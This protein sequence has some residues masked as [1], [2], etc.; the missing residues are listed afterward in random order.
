MWV[1]LKRKRPLCLEGFLEV[2]K[3]DSERGLTTVPVKESMGITKLRKTKWFCTID[4]WNKQ[5]LL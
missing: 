5:Q 1:D 4:E 3:V 2:V